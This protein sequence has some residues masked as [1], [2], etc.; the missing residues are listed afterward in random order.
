MMGE[1]PARPNLTF[2][3]EQHLQEHQDTQEHQ[4]HGQNAITA[5]RPGNTPE[6]NKIAQDTARLQITT[7]FLMGGALRR[8]LERYRENAFWTRLLF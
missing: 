4:W 7:W 8:L 5:D 3:E 2:E 1:K 6:R